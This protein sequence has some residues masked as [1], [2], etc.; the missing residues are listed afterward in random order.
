MSCYEQSREHQLQQPGSLR[1]PGESVFVH[2]KYIVGKCRFMS[3]PPD[4][5]LGLYYRDGEA[6]RRRRKRCSVD[7]SALKATF[8][9]HPIPAQAVG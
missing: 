1:R 3:T 6:R 4:L 9:F 8:G 2:D 5:M 7:P